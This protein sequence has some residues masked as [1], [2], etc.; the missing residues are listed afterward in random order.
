MNFIQLAEDISDATYSFQRDNLAARNSAL[1]ARISAAS[2]LRNSLTQLASALGDRVRNGDLSPQASISDASV[3]TVASAAGTSPK[4]SYTLEVSQLAQSQTLVSQSYTSADDLVGE[5]SLTIRFGAVDGASFTEDTAQTALNIAVDAS[6]TLET[7]A[8]KISGE[9]GGDLNAYVAQGTGGAQLVIK[10]RDGADNGFVLEPTSSAASPTQTP[11]DLS[12]LGW[13]PATDAGELRQTS[14]DAIFE[15]D[16]VAMRS[17]SNSV[18]GLPEGMTLELSGTNVGAPAN[19]AFSNDSAAITTV[20]ADFVAALNDLTGQL[21][22]VAA[23]QGGA[24]GNDPG[25]RE[26][27]RDLARLTSEIVMPSAAEGEPNTLSD[28][29]LSLSRDGTFRLDT[30]RLNET[31][32]A[33]PEGAAAMFTN[34]PFGVFATMDNLARANTVTGDPGSLGGSV[35]RYEDQIERNDSRLERI[36]EQQDGLR[37]RLTRNLVSAERQI[38]ASQSTLG[39]LQQQIEIWNS[40]N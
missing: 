2:L 12:Y 39:F 23:A 6:D 37:E 34:G 17:A 21:N 5:G 10:G 19:I 33:S 27:K 24:L 4:G 28:L 15:L 14:Q 18:T 25:A 11:G 26:L 20:M 35:S 40:S 38:S 9:S 7:L 29:G 30:D 3:A 31:L 36:A 32:V 22:E 1:E 8:A 13:T 16:T